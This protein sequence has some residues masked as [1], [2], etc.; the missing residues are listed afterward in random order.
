MLV[1]RH[2][3]GSKKTCGWKI[4][5]RH[6]SFSI[7]FFSYKSILRKFLMSN[8]FSS[9]SIF[10]SVPACKR[11]NFFCVNVSRNFTSLHY[12]TT[13]W[14]DFANVIYYTQ[15]S[16]VIFLRNLTSFPGIRTFV[17]IRKVRRP[18][19]EVVRSLNIRK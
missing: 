15:S 11:E 2:P 16:V 3:T 12:C 10:S 1:C 14:L 7:I 8:I 18:E 4:F 19:I 6:K 9:S 13:D 17:S 5:I